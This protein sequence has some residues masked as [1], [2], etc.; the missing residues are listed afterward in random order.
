[1]SALLVNAPRVRMH[2]RSATDRL[3]SREP[4]GLPVGRACQGCCRACA[5]GRKQH[6]QLA[7]GSAA[8]HE[9]IERR[10][11]LALVISE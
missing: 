8:K 6:G 1:M 9:R 10:R 4:C 2:P 5:D 7:H 3:T 11:R